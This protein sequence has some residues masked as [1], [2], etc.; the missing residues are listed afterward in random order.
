MNLLRTVTL[1]MEPINHDAAQTAER[2]Q[3]F[4]S[5]LKGRLDDMGWRTR[6]T[7]YAATPF[8]AAGSSTRSGADFVAFAMQMEALLGDS[9][10]CC[11]P[12]PAYG[13]FDEDSAAAVREMLVRTRHVFSNVLVGDSEGLSNVAVN[14]AANTMLE[15]GAEP[16][17]Q[18]ANFRFAAMANTNAGIPFFPASFHHGEPAFSVALELAHDFNICCAEN[19]GMQAKLRACREVLRSKVQ[20]LLPAMQALASEQGVR[21]AGFDFSLAPYPGE[22]T[23]A[24]SVIEQLCAARIGHVDFLFALYSL[25]DLLKHSTPTAPKVGFSGTMLSVLEDTR[26]AQAVADGE[27]GVTDLLLYSTVCGCGLDMI[28]VTH[29]V[30]PAQVASLIRAISTIAQKWNKPLIARILPSHVG[31]DGMTQY[32]H[33]FLVNTRVMPLDAVA[34]DADYA[35]RFTSLALATA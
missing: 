12:G 5:A 25:N 1:G 31:A 6:C 20:E 10:W 22:G 34:P 35:P 11:L 13:R 2:I 27:V 9:V 8:G 28:P 17:T 33:D 24:V 23:S 19:T 16:E 26:L 32:S 29:D 18:M 7:R 3:S 4:F 21:F 14:A 30:Q 15:L